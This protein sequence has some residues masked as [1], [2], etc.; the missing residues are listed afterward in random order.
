MERRKGRRS[1]PAPRW[2][3][4]GVR[5]GCLGSWPPKR[6]RTARRVLL[7]KSRGGS[8]GLV[9]R[10]RSGTKEPAPSFGRPTVGAPPQATRGTRG[11]NGPRAGPQ[12]AFRSETRGVS[13]SFIGRLSVKRGEGATPSPRTNSPPE[14]PRVPHGR[15]FPRPRSYSTNHATG[16]KEICPAGQFFKCMKILTIVSETTTGPR[17]SCPAGRSSVRQCG[18]RAQ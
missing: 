1:R 3:G 5:A 13:G 18:S 14:T 17:V 8:S 12:E 11:V 16:F 6:R 9:V 15:C 7:A 4:R 10:S 2:G